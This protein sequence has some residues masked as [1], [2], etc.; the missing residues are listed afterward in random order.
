MHTL[1]STYKSVAKCSL[2][3]HEHIKVVF[4]AR[5]KPV[6]GIYNVHIRV[7]SVD[8]KHR[9][10]LSRGMTPGWRARQMNSEDWQA[11]VT[12]R[13]IHWRAHLRSSA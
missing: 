11:I 1:V 10:R 5:A 4:L 7:S 3:K 6:Q 13:G 8:I 12:I 2:P 9:L